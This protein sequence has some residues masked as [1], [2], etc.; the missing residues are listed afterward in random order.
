[1]LPPSPNFLLQLR[2]ACTQAVPRL[3]CT[4]T[5][6]LQGSLET[7]VMTVGQGSPGSKTTYAINMLKIIMR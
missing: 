5:T 3:L 1:M 7:V 6:V 2:R 4:A